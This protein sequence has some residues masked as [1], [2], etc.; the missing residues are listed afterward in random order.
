NVSDVSMGEIRDFVQRTFKPVA[1]QKGLEF[2]VDIDPAVPSPMYTDG[3]RLEQV[4]KNL[5]SN[6]FKFTE[7]GSV[8]LAIH[9][10]ETS[11]RY[12][13]RTLDH[14]PGGVIAFEVRDTGVGIPKG[15]QQL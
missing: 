4:L 8:T 11:R 14:A 2:I 7:R 13:S 1:G 6:A 10:A 3:Q 9:L 12:A 15:K 5:L